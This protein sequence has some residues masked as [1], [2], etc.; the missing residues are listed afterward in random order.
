M[1]I[2]L[3]ECTVK[4]LNQAGRNNYPYNPKFVGTRGTEPVTSYLTNVLQF[5]TISADKFL[6]E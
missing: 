4:L 2:H 1:H 6:E 5:Y 3:A